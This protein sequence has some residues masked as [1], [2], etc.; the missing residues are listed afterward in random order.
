MRIKS[1][2]Y[3]L[4]TF[5]LCG[6]VATWVAVGGNYKSGSENYTVE[7]PEGWRQYTPAKGKLL[8]TKDGFTLQRIQI[9]RAKIDTKLTHTKKKFEKGMLPQ[10]AAEVV[11]DNLR[12]NPN[13]L[14]QN[15]V[16]NKPVQIGGHSGF[17]IVYTYQNKDGLNKKGVFCGLLTSDWWYEMVY[18]AP[19]RHYFAKDL[20]AFEKVIETFRLIKDA[21]A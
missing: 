18:E 1:A 10:E 14:N 4:L 8:I 11:I 13:I 16:E 15:V 17:K 3:L 12:S 6:C 7:L 2:L 20:P 5:M 19:E 9:V 21:A